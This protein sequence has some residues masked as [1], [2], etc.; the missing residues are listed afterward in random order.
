[1]YLLSVRTKFKTPAVKKQV[2][3]A[4]VIRG[5]PA[6]ATRLKDEAMQ[7]GVTALLAA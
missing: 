7:P 3:A 4:F 5:L 2:E 1:V 6:T